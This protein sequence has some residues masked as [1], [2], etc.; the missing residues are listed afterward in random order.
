M[1]ITVKSI[2]IEP[3]NDNSSDS[4]SSKDDYPLL[5]QKTSSG[6]PSNQCRFQMSIEPAVAFHLV[7]MFGSI[8]GFKGIILLVIKVLQLHHVVLVLKES[9]LTRT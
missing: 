7:E 6:L 9:L 5:P 1:L 2:L 4:E 3:Y 8:D